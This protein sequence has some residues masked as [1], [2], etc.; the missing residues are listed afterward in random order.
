MN[1]RL[2]TGIALL[3]ALAGCGRPDPALSVRDAWVRPAP[4][5]AR[6]TAAYLVIENPGSEAAALTG[7]ECAAFGLAEIHET[8]VV[9]GMS[10]MRERPRVEVPAGGELVLSPGGLHVMLMR[11]A[12]P[13]PSEG[14]VPLVLVFEDGRRI[15]VEAPVGRPGG[16]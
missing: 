4:P 5:D 2:L 1:V 14:V 16:Q 12:G 13:M 7:V 9:D 10:R 15:E 6:M 3:V 11:P 8:V